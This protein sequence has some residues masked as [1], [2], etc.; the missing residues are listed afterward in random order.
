MRQTPD[1]ETS[2]GRLRALLKRNAFV[3]HTARSAREAVRILGRAYAERRALAGRQPVIRRYLDTH[4]VRKL[5]LGAGPAA[6][7]HDWLNSD[8]QPCDPS[9][10][11]LD[12][13]QPFPLP[14]GS[15]DYVFA[16]HLIQQFDYDQLERVLR[17]CYRVLRAGGRVRLSTPDLERLSALYGCQPGSIASRYITWAIDNHAPWAPTYLAGFVL[18]NLFRELPFLYDR[19]SLEFALSRTGFTQI[20]FVEPGESDDMHLRGLE[21]HGQVLGDEDINRF[22]SLVVEAAKPR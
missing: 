16:E 9:H 7:T 14:S 5:Q 17:E 1:P 4:S 19:S 3:A 18:N 6:A 10:I 15:F 12:A 22:E 11:F 20:L 2:P 21:V 8:L 13:L